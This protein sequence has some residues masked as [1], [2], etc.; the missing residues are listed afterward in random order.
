MF[1]QVNEVKLF[2]QSCTTRIQLG[3]DSNPGLSASQV[4][5]L[6]DGK[7]RQVKDDLGV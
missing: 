7:N 6:I 5:V 4:C 2:A 3:G 1:R